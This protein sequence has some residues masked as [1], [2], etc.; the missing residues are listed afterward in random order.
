MLVFG[1]WCIGR[2]VLRL[3]AFPGATN[4][5]SDE[6]E[7][8]FSKY[9]VRM[10]DHS[11]DSMI[12]LCTL[13]ITKFDASSA[14]VDSGSH[15]QRQ[16]QSLFKTQ[17][18]KALLSGYGQYDVIPLWSKACSYRDR[19]L[20][21]YY[22]VLLNLL[23]N[24]R[25]GGDNADGDSNKDVDLTDNTTTSAEAT[26]P[27]TAT[28]ESYRY[29][30]SKY[31]NNCLIGDVGNL[32]TITPQA[33]LDG[34]ALL[35]LLRNVL[36]DLENLKEQGKVLLTS[37]IKS[38][39]KKKMSKEGIQ[40]AFQLLSSATE[41]KK[42]LHNFE[43]SSL[44]QLSEEEKETGKME[45]EPVKVR[46]DDNGRRIV[47]EETIQNPSPFLSMKLGAM[48]VLNLVDPPA[49]KS[50]FGLDV[51]RGT[52]LS[53]YMGARQLWV[54]RSAK[55]G[56]GMLD[57]LHIPSPNASHND[58]TK[59]IVKAVLFCNPNAGLVEVGT[60]MSLTGGNVVLDGRNP[61]STICWTD[62]YTESGYDIFL[63]NYCGFGRSY[64][65]NNGTI[66]KDA[67]TSGIIKCSKR[68]VRNLLFGFKPSPASI[69]SDSLTM[70][71]HIIQKIGADSLVVHGESIGGMA[72]A[73][74]ARELSD[75]NH[76]DAKT[77]FPVTHPTLLICDRTFC[78]LDAVAQ[79]L[80]GSWTGAVLPL[81]IPL[82]K[83]DVAADFAAANCKKI[84]AQDASDA[85]IHDAS[86][87]KSG[88]A[89]AKESGRCETKGAGGYSDTPMQYRMADWENV[90]VLE[91][92][93]VTDS[94]INQL[95][96]PIWASDKHIH[97]NEAIHFAAC[98]ERIGK[99]ATSLRREKEQIDHSR[100]SGG[101]YYCEEEGI[102]IAALL[103]RDTPSVEDLEQELTCDNLGGNI[104]RLWT[105]LSRCDGMT[106]MPLGAAVKG[107]HDCVL[108]WLFSMVT[109]GCQRV[110]LQAEKRRKGLQPSLSPLSSSDILVTDED[111]SIE[112]DCAVDDLT[113][114]KKALLLPLPAVLKILKEI[115]EDT[116]GI[117]GVQ[118]EL[119]Y[120]IK[121]LDYAMVRMKA[122]STVSSALNASHFRDTFDGFTS[123]LFINLTC[124]HNNQYSAGERQ[125]LLSLLNEAC[126]TGYSIA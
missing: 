90:G 58:S 28:D 16:H 68:V 81:L 114:V 98:I 74:T 82:W 19:V 25:I 36:R 44:I 118:T 92:S 39:D 55:D 10:L 99:V 64:T 88:L 14:I 48:A 15:R 87:L 72:A 75:M 32:S 63:F 34:D 84:V 113:E 97:R 47:A 52:V 80:V 33:R 91:S 20:G 46:H 123:G 26:T 2:F 40:A 65:G 117:Q 62:F 9:S 56:G 60:G 61:N 104:I 73:S 13:L 103:S 116:A 111:F 51:L 96:A 8:E 41:L 79:R 50:I 30:L 29:R 86:S 121:M 45:K 42:N 101:S 1:I 69:K 126:E 108:A 21:M 22:D 112:L 24:G 23:T 35:Q 31:G 18:N 27:F 70:A 4:R 122:Q 115:V 78:N 94:K 124:G 106:G 77:F 57:V 102:E 95:Q 100:D 119:H 11:A 110:A 37:S 59:K 83:T 107:G 85:I 109:F 38:L 105:T 49:H 76:P 43:P 125:H 67:Y 71:L 53:R 7:T 66:K 5:V 3:I 6:V 120:C 93:F 89:M 17:D 54:P 12:D